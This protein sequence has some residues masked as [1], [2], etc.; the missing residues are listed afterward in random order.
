MTLATKQP[1]AARHGSGTR[2]RV[3]LVAGLLTA[4]LGGLIILGWHLHLTRVVQLGPSVA[5]MQYNT[6]L[7]FLLSGLSLVVGDRSV[8]STRRAR[9]AVAG[10]A[11]VAALGL[12][13]VLEYVA[14]WDLAIDQVLYT[15]REAPVG[16]YPGRMA[17]NTALCFLVTGL[18][19]CL[20]AG[21]TIAGWRSVVGAMLAAIALAFAVAALLGYATDLTAAFA[22]SGFIGMAAQTA[23]GFLVLGVGVLA[24]AWLGSVENE[25]MPSWL[26]VPAAVMVLVLAL[27]LAAGLRHQEDAY[28]IRA[29]A[30]VAEEVAERVAADTRERLRALERMAL[31]W[32]AVDGGSPRSLWEADAKTYLR[33]FPGYRAL[34]WANDR[35]TA[36][37]LVGDRS[38]SDVLARASAIRRRAFVAARRTGAATATRPFAL[39]RRVPG[40]VLVVPIRR[41]DVFEGFLVA[42]VDLRTQLAAV[43]GR[44]AT[45]YGMS[46]RESSRTMYVR[47]EPRVGTSESRT[48]DVPGTRLV[49]TVWPG[50]AVV[51]AAS[52]RL[53]LVAVVVGL[54]AAVLVMLATW[55]WLRERR[56]ARD[57]ARA[58]AVRRELAAIVE[59]SDDA[60]VSLDREG[61]IRSW[62]AGAERVTG[63]SAEEAIGRAATF[64]IPDDVVTADVEALTSVMGGVRLRDY[65]TA[66]IHRDGHRIDM[67]MT[68]SPLV[69]DRGVVSG[70]AVVGRD[71]TWQKRAQV[72]LLQ[73]KERAEAANRA[74][75][76]FL[77]N[78]SHEI[79][80]PMNAVLGFSELLS[81]LNLPDAAR[82]HV[83]LVRTAGQDLM[84][85]IDDILDFSKIEAGKLTVERIRFDPRARCVDTV[86]T[87]RVRAAQKGLE[88]SCW[89]HPQIPD[90]VVGDPFRIAQILINL[91]GNA[92][93]FTERGA[94]RVAVTAADMAHGD[95][96]LSFS[97]TDTGIGIA[98]D[99]VAAIFEAFEQADNSV[100]RRYGGTGLGLAISARLARL[101]GGELRV[102]SRL[103]VGSTFSFSVV[104]APVASSDDA[105]PHASEVIQADA[106]TS[107]RPVRVLVAEDNLVNQQLIKALLHADGHS[108]TLVK[109]GR[110]AIAAVEAERYDLVL[111]DVQM[112]VMDGLEATAEIR[113]REGSSGERIP[114]IALTAGAMRGDRE[115]CLDV[116]MDDF[117]TKPVSMAALRRVLHAPQA[118]AMPAEELAPAGDDPLTIA[119]VAQALEIDLELARE[120]ADC[121]LTTGPGLLARVEHAVASGDGAALTVAAHALKGSLAPF[122][123]GSA[124]RAAQALESMERGGTLDLAAET[125]EQLSEAMR[126]LL[127]GLTPAATPP[128]AR[129]VG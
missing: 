28:V 111:M 57:T 86:E 65:A 49:A 118:S 13:T 67:A 89:V 77:A 3:V 24:Q 113:A 34:A 38:G 95:L 108:V 45:G 15:V 79:R 128:A 52:T 32:V 64:A 47:D 87:L 63:Y 8:T 69:D 33:D 107:N 2:A 43:L 76:E 9:W 10:G 112:P 127:R 23:V 93:K 74:K 90:V 124:W 21:T 115:R 106:G 27:A 83:R 78:M 129:A 58:H 101:L 70:M 82:E 1:A 7:A 37:R 114:I 71:V 84:V 55:L 29:T 117:I 16:T 48:I 51:A 99:R 17:P 80:T 18:A 22:W 96:R 100:T 121:L 40:V 35:G 116:G 75:S 44:V 5:P 26:P 12:L 98:A 122:G 19:I 66:R 119:E 54:G 103:G 41:D 4:V 36:L 30:I 120:L 60:I 105:A 125:F 85:V 102:D 42:V 72:E 61:V 46:V 20:T 68:L 11:V 6:A 81:T 110:A 59:S 39:A 50:P 94:I 14:G 123:K 92:I 97:V 56:A 104:V 31:R 62:N 88:L 73:A 91:V 126:T 109:D 53:P 25:E